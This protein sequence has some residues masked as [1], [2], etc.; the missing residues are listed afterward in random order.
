MLTEGSGS[1]KTQL[2]DRYNFVLSVLNN[3]S[4]S[5]MENLLCGWN[6]WLGFWDEED[7]YHVQKQ[8]EH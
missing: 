7:E 5:W 2:S 1:E 8:V 3:S 4:T 6:S